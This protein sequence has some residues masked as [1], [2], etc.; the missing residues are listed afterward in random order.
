MCIFSN[1][2]LLQWV[3]PSTSISS[4]RYTLQLVPPSKVSPP[5]SMSSNGYLPQKVFP[6]IS[7]SM[8]VR[9]LE[10]GLRGGSSMAIGGKLSKNSIEIL[11]KQNDCRS[12]TNFECNDG[13]D[14]FYPFIIYHPKSVLQ[15]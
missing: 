10:Y 12:F 11:C 14:V 13:I 9:R 5:I 8:Q 2:Y 4:N 15:Y 1:K 3:P 7:I 6:P